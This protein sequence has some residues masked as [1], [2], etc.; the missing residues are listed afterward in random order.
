MS[1]TLKEVNE[2]LTF[3][4]E[5]DPFEVVEEGDIQINI[6]KITSKDKKFLKEDVYIS[7][8]YVKN[9]RYK[10]EFLDVYFVNPVE[11]KVITFN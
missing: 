3:T 8:R 9:G 7:K 4:D 2:L 5:K 11:K 6:F 1:Y 10:T